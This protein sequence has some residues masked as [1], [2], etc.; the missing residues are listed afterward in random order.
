MLRVSPSATRQVKPSATSIQDMCATF[1]RRLPSPLIINGVGSA[2]TRE[3]IKAVTSWVR[4]RFFSYPFVL[5][6]VRYNRLWTPRRRKA[7]A[8]FS[9]PTP[10]LLWHSM[11]NM[12]SHPCLHIYFL[13][14][15]LV[16]KMSYALKQLRH[17]HTSPKLAFK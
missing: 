13:W 1:V 10:L 16:C 14:D 17:S 15:W 3:Q 11:M 9:L 5:G 8:S 4:Q 6:V 7:Y 2:L 12:M